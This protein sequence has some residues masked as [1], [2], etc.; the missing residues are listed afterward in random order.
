MKYMAF[1]LGLM[2][3][4]CR[5]CGH[6]FYVKSTQPPVQADEG[7][8]DEPLPEPETPVAVLPLQPAAVVPA[9]D[10]PAAVSVVGEE[11]KARKKGLKVRLKIR[12]KAF[13][14]AS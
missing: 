2:M 6:R 1:A 11:T 3:M 14:A 12:T 7:L 9:P 10:V 5:A 13:R 4:T 8:F